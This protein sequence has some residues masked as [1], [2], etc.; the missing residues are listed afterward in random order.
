MRK[1]LSM[2]LVF[3]LV[4]T[5]S[6]LPAY[7]EEQPE[8]SAPAAQVLQDNLVVTEHEAVIQGQRVP[9]T[10]TTGT[11]ALS[12]SL[13]Q[14]EIFF[15]AYTRSDADDLTQRPITSPSTAAPAVPASGC[16]LAF[17]AH[18]AWSLTPSAWRHS[19]R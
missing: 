13:G 10:A 6:L 18:A 8:A 12:S 19:F 11:M 2:L 15:T 17:S 4:L 1:S 9:Y 16:S 3:I 5:A 7:A 14:Y